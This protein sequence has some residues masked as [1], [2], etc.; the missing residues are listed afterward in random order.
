MLEPEGAGLTA[1]R[2]LNKRQ[3]S[4]HL[5]QLNFA[6]AQGE[7]SAGAGTARIASSDFASSDCPGQLEPFQGKQRLLVGTRRK[8]IFAVA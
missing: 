2:I 5:F 7:A 3:V 4:G 6:L 1:S 8:N